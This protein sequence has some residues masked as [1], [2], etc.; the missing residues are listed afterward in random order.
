MFASSSGEWREDPALTPTRHSRTWILGVAGILY[1]SEGLPYGIVTGL[2]P[3][4]LRLQHVGLGEIGLREV[5]T[6]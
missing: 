5:H 3:L 1:F 6:A 4:Y 2:F